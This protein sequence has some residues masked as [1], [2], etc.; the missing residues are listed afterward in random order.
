MQIAAVV[1]L[2]YGLSPKF[3]ALLVAMP[4][5]VL[6]GVFIIVCGMIAVSAIRLLQAAP[7]TTENHLVAGTTLIVA[8]GL[9]SYLRFALG[10]EWIEA[11]PTI[12]GITVTNEVVLAVLLGV[13][14]HAA[15]NL[16]PARGRHGKNSTE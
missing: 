14:L 6:G 10:T 9:P 16:A 15:L 12:V 1:L 3:G 8:I 11:L 7:R 4:R 2:L 13:G 5:S